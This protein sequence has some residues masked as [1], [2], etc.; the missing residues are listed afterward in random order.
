MLLAAFAILVLLAVTLIYQYLVKARSPPQ[1]GF[2]SKSKR[3]SYKT[4]GGSESFDVPSDLRQGSNSA[5]SAPS[6]TLVFLYMNGCGWCEKFK[7]EWDRFSSTYGPSLAANGVALVSYER[8]DAGAKQYDNYVQGY[9]TVLLAKSDGNVT[10]FQGDRTP[11]GLAE[12]L[13]QNGYTLK[14][15]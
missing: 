6:A 7:P 9:P 13:K 14:Q 4:R 11:Q 5:A 2:K 8:S 12:F 15:A 3:G 1:E 10:V